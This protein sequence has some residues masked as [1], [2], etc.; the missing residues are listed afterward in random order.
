[1]QNFATVVVLRFLI[2]VFEAG[3]F[4]GKCLIRWYNIELLECFKDAFLLIRQ[5]TLEN[6]ARKAYVF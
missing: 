1:V 3:F 6:G 2:G 4:P 5:S